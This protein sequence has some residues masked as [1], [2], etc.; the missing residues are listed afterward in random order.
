ML[1]AGVT[2]LHA[3]RREHGYRSLPCLGGIHHRH[4]SHV[5]LFFVRAVFGAKV[6]SFLR[7]TGGG[8]PP[9]GPGSLRGDFVTFFRGSA[10]RGRAATFMGL[11]FGWGR[12]GA[13]L[14]TGQFFGNPS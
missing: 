4:G 9:L 2:P 6:Y 11:L 5:F 14:G 12:A 7:A 8:K 1:L 10:T 3:W 13:P